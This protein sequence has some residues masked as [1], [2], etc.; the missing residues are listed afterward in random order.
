[1]S[2]INPSALGES[3][4][5]E[6]EAKIAACTTSEE[7]KALMH[8]RSIRIGV[9]RPDVYDNS[10]LLP[11]APGTA[12]KGYAKTVVVDG[13]KHVLGPFATELELA[14]KENELFRS[15]FTDRPATQTRTE[16]ARDAETGRFVERSE[17][18]P[19]SDEEKSALALQFQLGQISVA[20]YLEKTGAVAE[21]LNK[22]GVPLE[23]LQEV[24]AEKNEQRFQQSW[25]DATEEFRNSPAGANW[26]G[27]QRNLDTI[28][29]IISESPELAN[30]PSVDA[31]AAAYE[32]MKQHN[33]VAENENVAISRATS[34]E[35]IQ[36]LV[37]YSGSSLFGR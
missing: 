20:E 10:V 11:V 35:E 32:Y 8:D 15:T 5:A 21:Y 33:L 26:P 29:R 22:A 30:N 14:Q 27:G 28:G 25:A 34:H 24:V 2:D 19:I 9:T 16:H 3:F 18:T 17:S 6:F 36:R 4:D 7:I 37:G 31:L 23:H 13:Q 1:M 12:P